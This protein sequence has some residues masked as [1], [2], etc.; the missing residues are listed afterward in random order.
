LALCRVL[1]ADNLPCA[2]MQEL[3]DC[4]TE[5]DRGCNGGLMDYAYQFIIDN[6]VRV[7]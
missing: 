7:C 2:A 5:E 6:G 4:D 1:R 3:V